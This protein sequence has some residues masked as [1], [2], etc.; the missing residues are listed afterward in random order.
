MGRPLVS[1]RRRPW[2]ASCRQIRW[3]FAVG[4]ASRAASIGVATVA[5]PS[6]ARILGAKL[7]LLCVGIR[8]LC[9]GLWCRCERREAEH[10]YEL[11][12]DEP[13]S[14]GQQLTQPAITALVSPVA[15][16]LRSSGSRPEISSA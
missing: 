6:I 4:S 3:T 15:Y 2:S 13:T 7:L 16:A 14:K 1:E 10:A 8:I 9:P 5:S 12:A 11:N